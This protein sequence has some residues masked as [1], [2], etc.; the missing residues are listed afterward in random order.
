MPLGARKDRQPLKNQRRATSIKEGRPLC[1]RGPFWSCGL[2]RSE[3][4]LPPEAGCPRAEPGGF[5]C[6]CQVPKRLL[7]R[8]HVLFPDRDPLLCKKQQWGLH[9]GERLSLTSDHHCG[10][11]G[12]ARIRSQPARKKHQRAQL[13]ALLMTVTLRTPRTHSPCREHGGRSKREGARTSSAL[14]PS[15][16]RERGAEAQLTGSVGARRTLL[17]ASVSAQ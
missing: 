11:P 16:D 5:P 4:S 3:V 14:L 9:G 10:Q 6:G 12:R 15:L 2:R 1:L 8:W 17:P 13:G 7:L